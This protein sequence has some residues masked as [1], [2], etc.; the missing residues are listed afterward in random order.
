L[1]QNF[2]CLPYLPLRTLSCKITNISRA[3]FENRGPFEYSNPHHYSGWSQW[4]C[5]VLPP[6]VHSY[7]RENSGGPL[8]GPKKVRIWV[9][10]SYFRPPL[11]KKYVLGGR[12]RYQIPPF[13]KLT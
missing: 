8:R 7:A 11:T 1:E 2:A 3:N 9:R 6:Y 12:L 10:N 4:K 13:L 5:T